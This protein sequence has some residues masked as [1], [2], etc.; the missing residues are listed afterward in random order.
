MDVLDWSAAAAAAVDLFFGS[1]SFIIEPL[2][3]S[4]TIII[5]DV[6]HADDDDGDETASHE[7]RIVRRKG[8]C[9]PL[10]TFSVS[11]QT[12]DERVSSVFR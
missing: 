12:H 9:L 1:P 7:I 3:P 2:L 6:R 4:L 5:T 8:R 10:M 11:D